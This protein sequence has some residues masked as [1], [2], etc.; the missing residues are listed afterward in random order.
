[1]ASP[2]AEHQTQT[3]TRHNDRCHSTA[4]LGSLDYTQY[5]AKP[6]L[7]KNRPVRDM[8]RTARHYTAFPLC[9]NTQHE[10]AHRS[11]SF[12]LAPKEDLRKDREGGQIARPQIFP[13]AFYAPRMASHMASNSMQ[14]PTPK[15]SQKRVTRVTGYHPEY[16]LRPL[17]EWSPLRGRNLARLPL[18]HVLRKYSS[19]S[20][21]SPSYVPGVR[22]MT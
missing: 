15:A 16:R 17:A 22:L 9:R 19:V 6:G 3:R 5:I 21:S 10:R 13:L 12:W 11:P 14:K 4:L 20:P 1:M 2:T 18:F 8:Y 7:D